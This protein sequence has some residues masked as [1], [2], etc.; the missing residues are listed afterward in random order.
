MKRG[1]CTAAQCRV[2]QLRVL[3]VVAD[4]GLQEQPAWH[5]SLE[6]RL[7]RC[8]AACMRCP[9]REGRRRTAHRDGFKGILSGLG[10][11]AGWRNHARARHAN[12]GGTA[13]CAN[14]KPPFARRAVTN[15]SSL[16]SLLSLS[17]LSQSHIVSLFSV[18][19]SI[20]YNYKTDGSISIRAPFKI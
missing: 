20:P 4:C 9:T 1:A 10:T 18:S 12:A 14:M 17:L 5:P 13:L 2:P 16:P 15:F 7:S 3:A 19:L 8:T 6:R 11:S